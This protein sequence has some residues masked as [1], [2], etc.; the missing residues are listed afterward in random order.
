MKYYIYKKKKNMIGRTS[1][2]LKK[3]KVPFRNGD[4]VY[5]VDWEGIL[6]SRWN[7]VF[8]NEIGIK[9]K[10]KPERTV[11]L[12]YEELIEYKDN[13]IYEISDI[14]AK[15]IDKY[16]IHKLNIYPFYDISSDSIELSNILGFLREK[17]FDNE[18]YIDINKND[19][20]LFDNYHLIISKNYGVIIFKAFDF[21]LFDD[22][23]LINALINDINLNSIYKTLCASSFLSDDGI[24]LNINYSLFYIFESI[25]DDRYTMINNRLNNNCKICNLKQFIQELEIINK[26][27]NDSVITKDIHYGILQMLKPQYVNS[28]IENLSLKKLKFLP[29]YS[30]ELDDTQKEILELMN[31]RC[32]LKASAGSGK[33]ILLL[34][35][36]Y[37][38][39]KLNPEKIFLII[40]F[41]SKLAEDIRILSVNTGKVRSNLRIL[42][43]DKF[44]EEKYS[45]YE[46]I[47]A[48]DQFNHRRKEFVNKV[49]SGKI[50]EHYGG[51]FI[52]EMQQLSEEYISTFIDLLDD[53]KYI[54]IAGDYYQQIGSAA[55]EYD[56]EDEEEIDDVSDDNFY[57]GDY[58]FLKIIIDRNYRNTEQIA[59]VINKMVKKIKEYVEKLDVHYLEKQKTIVPGKSSLQSI[60]KPEYYIVNSKTEEVKKLIEI[61]RDLL[62]NKHLYPKEILIIT[63]WYNN[64]NTVLSRKNNNYKN[65]TIYK[66]EEEMKKSGI[67]FCDFNE[68]PS[69]S[70]S[71]LSSDGI[72]IG[73]IGKSIGLDFKAVIMC[74]IENWKK[75]IDFV[76]LEELKSKDDKV[77]RGFIKNLKNI[78]VACSRAREMLFI[79][80]NCENTQSDG[81]ISKFLSLAGDENE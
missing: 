41:N 21:D 37:E 8:E 3:E 47:K 80:D 34:S 61:I 43:F 13:R 38:V 81:L 14:D 46:D 6:H 50:L 66:I 54:V 15:K 77:K 70:K 59:D 52:D 22:N 55:D 73:S 69:S 5:L 12:N 25:Y 44:I 29:E 28:K 65:Y 23:S 76:N 7:V 72:R 31:E 27:S 58:N 32:Y 19:N 18:V 9:L 10:K 16:F 60:Y 75:T 1:F 2:I 11:S 64:L 33:T 51:I 42:T 79:I 53:N 62:V 20:S 35:K 40:C 67:S 57:I 24:K 63:P 56:E 71:K 78:Y 30:Y 48:S 36:A 4:L 17:D 68:S 45:Q 49:S 39:A 26:K 74:G